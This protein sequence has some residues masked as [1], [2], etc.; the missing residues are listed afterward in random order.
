MIH[1]HEVPGEVTFR[2]TEVE[3]RL[4]GAGREGNGD[5]LKT[6]KHTKNHVERLLSLNRWGN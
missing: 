4:P 2:E 3:G 1:F 5:L 6:K